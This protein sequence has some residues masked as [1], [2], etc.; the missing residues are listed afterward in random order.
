[1]GASTRAG[2]ALI[3]DPVDVTTCSCTSGAISLGNAGRWLEALAGAG[4]PEEGNL[5][6][7]SGG[8]HA[9]RSAAGVVGCAGAL[10]AA[11]GAPGGMGDERVAPAWLL[12]YVGARARTNASQ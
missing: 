6:A 10:R 5:N 8:C 7:G 2:S 4:E 1:M 12:M 9:A 11:Q 3:A